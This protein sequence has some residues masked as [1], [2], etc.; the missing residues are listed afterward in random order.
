MKVVMIRSNPVNP[1]SR[2][3]KEVNSLIKS[4]VTVKILAWDRSRRGKT[5]KSTLKLASG[6]V[7]IYRICIPAL[8]GA[9]F[10]KN[11]IPLI[12]FQVKIVHWLLKHKSEYD[13]VHAC[14]FDTAF[15]SNIIARWLRKKFIY[16]IFDYY[17]DS[18][19]VPNFIKSR[20]ERLDHS[21]INSANAVI[22]CSEQ[23]VVQISGASPKRLEFIHN[24]PQSIPQS[25]FD[26]PPRVN[27]KLKIV[28]VGILSKGRFLKEIS[29]FIINNSHV[30]LHIG[31]FGEYSQYFQELAGDY[32]NI[33][34]YGK[35]PYEQTILLEKSCDIITA[36][37][38]PDVKNHYYAAP[39]KF[40]EALMLGKPV[41]M[42]KN[43]GMSDLVSKYDIGEVIDFNIESFRQ[44]IKNLESRRYE[45]EDMSRRMRKIYVEK[46]SWT[47]MERR[48]TELYRDI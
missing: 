13:V 23:R 21:V 16:D 33:Y 44:A 1:D 35:I 36:I 46:Y 3:E 41:I 45:W 14:D 10:K 32:E 38:D 4:G 5:E 42:V 6:V 9:G 25:N 24:T 28:Y 7:D 47:E 15:T 29:N 22:L 27:N 20:I 37:Y 40:Y 19:H 12:L 8:F 2:V 11:L 34:F 17:V 26:L 39:N 18:F 48:L 30:E 31:G 43:T